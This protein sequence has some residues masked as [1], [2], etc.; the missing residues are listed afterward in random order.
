MWKNAVALLSQISVAASRDSRSD[1]AY[2]GERERE[3]DSHMPSKLIALLSPSRS[4]QSDVRA[5]V[6][7]KLVCVCYLHRP[8]RVVLCFLPFVVR[9]VN[10]EIEVQTRS[11]L[12]AISEKRSRARQKV[13]FKLKMDHVERDELPQLQ[14]LMDRDSYMK[15]YEKEIRRR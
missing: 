7:P 2:R 14:Q 8:G 5:R 6:N 10:E 13:K 9:A 1:T 3:S 15:P 12:D 11:R 4:T